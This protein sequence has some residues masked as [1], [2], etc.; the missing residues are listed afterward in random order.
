MSGSR[1]NLVLLVA[2]HKQYDAVS[3]GHVGNEVKRLVEQGGCLLQV[4]YE[5]GKSAAVEV[6]LHVGVEGTWVGNDIKIVS[7]I[8][9][10][11]SLSCTKLPVSRKLRVA[12]QKLRS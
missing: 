12:R 2:T 6:G 10:F 5:V 7:H 3:V 8:F 11:P 9:F 1:T 4:Y